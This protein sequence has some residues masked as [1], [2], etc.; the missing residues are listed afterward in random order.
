METT[1]AR[2]IFMTRTNPTSP[3]GPNLL[4][5]PF[6]RFL[7]RTISYKSSV[8][9]SIFSSVFL[10]SLHPRQPLPQIPVQILGCYLVCPWDCKPAGQQTRHKCVVL[11]RRPRDPSQPETRVSYFHWGPLDARPFEH[12]GSSEIPPDLCP[13]QQV[14]VPVTKDRVSLN[15][16]RFGV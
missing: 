4:F 14:N 9:Y 2:T 7:N 8:V 16:A 13:L 3:L 1:P 15:Q 5:F 10:F 11:V 6:C 12:V